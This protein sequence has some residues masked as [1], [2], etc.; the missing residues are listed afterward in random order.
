MKVKV[1]RSGYIFITITILLGIASANTLNNLL[2]MIVSALL[3]TMLVS[4]VI[5][6]IN[7]LGIDIKLL[8]PKEVYANRRTNFKIAARKRFF[9]PSFLIEIIAENGKAF[10]PIIERSEKIQEIPLLFK[11]RGIVKEIELKLFSDFPLG[12]FIRMNRIKIPVNLVIFPEPRPA[13]LNFIEELEKRE[14][15]SSIRTRI[16]GFDE[17]AGIKKY[18]REPLK[19]IHWKASA[20]RDELMVKELYAEERRPVILSMD[21]VEGDTEEKLSK[22]A[23]LVI[24]LIKEGYP[25]G[26][27][28]K[29]RLIPPNTGEKQKIKLLTELALY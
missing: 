8:P 28:I 2:Y 3:S 6:I 29:D 23:Y 21:M 7:L 1:K 5:S 22:L 14:G 17:F 16:K 26:L 27:K 12:M 19:L 11:K 20:K 13:P 24:K 25:V 18:E 15:V 9:I 4:G 10:F